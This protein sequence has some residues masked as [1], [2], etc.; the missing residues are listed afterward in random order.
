MGCAEIADGIPAEAKL[1]RNGPISQIAFPEQPNLFSLFICQRHV[2]PPL[3][4]PRKPR[5]P[6]M[7]VGRRFV[8]IDC[9]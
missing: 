5:F 9:F 6:E 4:F 1:C 8:V 7:T 3:L 2:S